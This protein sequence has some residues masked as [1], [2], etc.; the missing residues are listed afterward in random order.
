MKCNLKSILQERQLKITKVSNDTG[1]SRTTLTSLFNE[2]AKGIQF[3]TLET[4][5][6]YLNIT[7][8]E[9]FIQNKIDTTKDNNLYLISYIYIKNGDQGT[10]DAFKESNEIGDIKKLK[11]EIKKKL[12]SEKI[13]ILNIVNLSKI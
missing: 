8:N 5:C 2:K 1:I 10:G 6:N 13:I 9:L 3:S 4:L 11:E 7:T 12:N